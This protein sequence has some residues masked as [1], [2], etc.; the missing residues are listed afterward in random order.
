LPDRSLHPHAL[1]LL[2]LLLLLLVQ[3]LA[4]A[5]LKEVMPCASDLIGM[6]KTS[7]PSLYVADC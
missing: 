1:L 5:L 6:N 4:P 7:S 3:T 2:L